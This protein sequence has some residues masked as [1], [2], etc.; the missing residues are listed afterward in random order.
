VT[1]LSGWLAGRTP[2]PPAE[3]SLPPL[4]AEG[5]PRE[6]LAEEAAAA[7]ARALS[8]KGERDGA[9]DLLTADAL[10]T[11]ACEHAASAP[12]PEA[13]LLRILSRIGRQEG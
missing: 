13:A 3:L 11:Y 9:Y 12:D 1:G 4:D 10:I 8:G 7:L 2:A 6:R 5:D